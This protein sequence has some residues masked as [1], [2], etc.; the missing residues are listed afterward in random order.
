MVVIIGAGTA[1]SVTFPSPNVTT[2]DG[3]VSVNFS[4]SPNVE[5]L[6]EL[7]TF[8]AF[9]INL[10]TTQS[11]SLTNYGGVTSPVELIPNEDCSES[12]AKVEV[13]ITPKI[14]DPSG[15]PLSPIVLTGDDAVYITSFSYSKDFQGYGQ[16][17]WSLQ[18]PP[19]I[20]D[21]TGSLAFIQG[22]ADGNRLTGADIVGD[23]STPP[24]VLNTPIALSAQPEDGIV[25][26]S[27]DPLNTDFFDAESRNIQ[28]SAGSPG[29]GQDDTQQ[30]GKILF[31]GGGAGKQDGKRGTASANIPHQQVFF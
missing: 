10:T 3:F 28:V 17:S 18:G 27:S 8:D 7:G 5:R 25:M 26:T 23:V 11:V 15:T 2:S 22:F 1:L 9:D 29:M 30:F 24:F 14:C 21:F 19:I 20:E 16:E 12:S 4:A 6:F 31:V 13:T